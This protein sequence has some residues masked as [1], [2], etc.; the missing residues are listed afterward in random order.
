[1]VNLNQ[2]NILYAL[3]KNEIKTQRQLAGFVNLAVS[4]VNSNLKN[5]DAMGLIEEFRLTRKGLKILSQ[6][7]VENAVIMAAGMSTRFAP[8]SYETPKGL[9]KVKGEILIERQ[10]EQLQEAGVNEIIVVVGYMKEKFFYLEDKYGVKIVINEEYYKCNNTSTLYLVRDQLK[11]TY[12][13]SSDNYFVH[14]VFA[15]HVFDS[16]Y[17]CVYQEGSTEEYCVEVY[18]S[19]Q[20]KNVTI[21]GKDSLVMLGHV[22][23]SK[24]F[25]EKFAEILECEYRL[26]GVNQMLWEQLYMQHSKELDFYVQEYQ[27]NEVLEF[28][29]LQE[30]QKFDASFIDNVDSK[31]LE[32]IMKIL[33]CQRREIVE[34]TPIKKGLTNISFSFVV[35]NKK[36]VYR[37]PGA[38]TEVIIN[39]QSEAFS[40][41]KASELGLD[42]TFLY[43]EPKEGW[44]I[45][46]YLEDTIDFDYHNE[47]DVKKVLP[48]I[49]KLHDSQIISKWNFDIMHECE[50]M[51]VLMQASQKSTFHDFD[52]LRNRM[53][54]LYQQ[55]EQDGVKKCLCHN[56]CYAPNFLTDGDKMFLI[57]WEY[58]GNC[59]PASDLGTFIC[60]SDYNEQQIKNVLN[61][62]FSRELTALEY[63][64]YIAYVAISG[65]YW[66]I[67]AL[68]KESV[69]N[70]VG[71]YLYI[72]YKYS[73]KY[74]EVALELYVKEKV[75]L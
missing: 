13:C 2:F 60:C 16:Y 44:K 22:Y 35:Q 30:L 68:Y 11:N 4:S 1:M 10:I 7:K 9:L 55:V 39:R 45:S 57:D 42:K 43:I 8:I 64:H 50:K 37:H 71:E 69:G 6:Y 3:Y 49:K 51:L 74:S 61:L 26:P 53:I 38:G 46:Y 47:E 15:S 48:L 65:Y 23:F 58:S 25:S 72:W 63:R 70:L 32:N 5:L 40:Q 17:S 56:D 20:I 62:Y 12:I 66:F 36:Y 75:Q 33:K 21:G 31:I 54:N 41:G 27:A 29:N 28:D 19:K 24:K 67:W 73:K 52:K 34:F 59:D 14:N 18:K